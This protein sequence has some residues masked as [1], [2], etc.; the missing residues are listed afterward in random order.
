MEREGK[1]GGL[2]PGVILVTARKVG[3]E[4]GGGAKRRDLTIFCSCSAL[5]DHIAGAG[6]KRGH[7]ASPFD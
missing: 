6:D 4:E 7:T 3:R 1:E 5:G 2:T